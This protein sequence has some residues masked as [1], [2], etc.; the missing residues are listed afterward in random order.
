VEADGDRSTPRE[1]LFAGVR[2]RYG[3]EGS[4]E[5]LMQAYH[6][7]Y[8]AA[9]DFPDASRVA[10]RGLRSAGWKVGVVTNGPRLQEQ[11]FAV[12]RLDDEVDGSCISALV[13]SWKSDPGIFVEAARRCGT[14]MDGWMVG[15]SGSADI[16]VGQGVGLRTIW[17]PRGRDWEL[18]PPLPDATASDIPEAVAI[19]LGEAGPA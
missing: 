16:R 15:D 4:D 6:R 17:F 9:F 3:V 1:E 2:D 12:T 5:E 11:E 18:G 10:L 14:E 13:D 7:D 8:P 19:I